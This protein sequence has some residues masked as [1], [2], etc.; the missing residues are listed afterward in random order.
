MV[1]S[2]VFEDATPYWPDGTYGFRLRLQVLLR[3]ELPIPFKPLLPELEGFSKDKSWG[4]ALQTSQREL[5]PRDSAYLWERLREAAAP[6]RR[7]ES[8]LRVAEGEPDEPY[9]GRR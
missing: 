9:G 7:L 5:V 4:T 1:S 6:I 8:G 3:A 2:E